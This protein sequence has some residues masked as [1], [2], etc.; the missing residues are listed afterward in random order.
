MRRVKG[1]TLVSEGSLRIGAVDN[2]L[3]APLF[4]T[5]SSHLPCNLLKDVSSQQ[6]IALVVKSCLQS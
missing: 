4:T 6:P 2:L 1:F 3:H 5:C